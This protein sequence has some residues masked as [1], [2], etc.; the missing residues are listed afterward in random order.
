MED[1]ILRFP[2]LGVQIFWSL[3]NCRSVDLGKT[4]LKEKSL[5]MIGLLSWGCSMD[6]GRL[7]Q[8]VWIGL[9]TILTLLC[10]SSNVEVFI[11]TFLTRGLLFQVIWRICNQ[12]QNF[13]KKVIKGWVATYLL[14]A[15]TYTPHQHAPRMQ[16]CVQTVLECLL[17]AH[18]R[19]HIASVCECL[20]TFAT[21]SSE[22]T[23][24]SDGLNKICKM[25]HWL[26]S[27]IIW[28]FA[29]NLWEFVKNSYLH[30]KWLC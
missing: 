8:H 3:L 13:K 21:H 24:S 23:Y 11:T 18:M 5:S 7:C 6:I 25:F 4:F 27:W 20:R 12:K 30:C 2:H 9:K 17:H 14:A 28:Q 15:R 26:K 1:M 19:L 22:I 29:R 16:V 10:I